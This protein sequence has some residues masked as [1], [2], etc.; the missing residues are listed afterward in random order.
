MVLLIGI[1]G[2]GLFVFT[3]PEFERNKP[4]VSMVDNNGFWNMKKPLVFKLDDESGLKSYSITL[5]DGEASYDLGHDLYLEPKRDALVSVEA[6]QRVSEIVTTEVTIIVE[7]TDASKWHFF[8]GNVRTHE[9]PLIIDT[10]RPK[11]SVVTNSYGIGKGGSA[12]VVYQVAEQYLRDFYIETKTGNRFKGQPFFKEGFYIS[13]IAWPVTVDDFGATLVAEDEAGNVSRASISL[14]LKKVEYPTR[15]LTLSEGYLEGKIRELAQEYP[16]TQ[17]VEERIEQFKI[18]NEEVRAANETLIQET[19]SFVPAEMID[20]FSIDPMYPLRNGKILGDFGDHRYYRYQGERVSESYHLGLDM[21]STKQAPITP[22]N[23]GEVVFAD[24]NGIYGNMPI[25]H[26]GMGL[27]TL[28][29]HCSTVHV[30][31]GDA[32]EP[33]TVIANT[34][35]T[36]SVLGDHLHFGVLVQGVEVRP[37]EWMDRQWIRLNITDVINDAKESIN[38]LGDPAAD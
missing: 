6:P 20:T 12:L 7:A 15:N 14:Y 4:M 2:A 23:G 27:Y 30:E 34:G 31:T 24:E 16:E 22:Q 33:G 18:I 10:K 36:G 3:S 37:Q 9:F 25:I 8:S 38:Q 17:G 21:A 29:G 32:I 11:V 28:Y 13:L 5:K 1:V 35:V 26:H 19:T